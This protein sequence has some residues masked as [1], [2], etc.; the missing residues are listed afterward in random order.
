MINFAMINNTYIEN[1]QV[2]NRLNTT[3][4]KIIRSQSLIMGC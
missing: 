1:L 2:T 3:L 4:R